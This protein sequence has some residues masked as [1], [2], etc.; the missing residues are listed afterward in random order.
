MNLYI[1]S[2]FISIIIVFSFTHKAEAQRVK[3]EL[4]FGMN[5]TQIDGDEIFGFHKYGLNMGV[6]AIFPFNKHWSISVETIF[7]QKGSYRKE[8]I[9]IDTLPTPYYNIRLNYLDVPV[10]VHYEDKGG[11][12]FGAGFSWGR[13]VGIEETEHGRIIETT[14]LA[15]PYK[16][17]DINVLAD[18]RIKIWK[19][20]KFNFR[21]AYSV[22]PIR[23]RVYN[24]SAGASWERTQY[25]SLLTF[26]LIYIFN[27]APER[28]SKPID[29]ETITN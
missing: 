28:S 7:N 11:F 17:D 20:L 24:N 16:R 27:E 15:G 21:Y 5:A 22:L 12:T 10:M 23:T 9:E 8:S 14:T 25:N 6:G 3:G 4:I 29:N 2:I 1:K 26:R 13:T 18:I 19:K